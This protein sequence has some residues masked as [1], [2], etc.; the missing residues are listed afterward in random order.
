MWRAAITVPDTSTINELDRRMVDMER[1]ALRN[2]SARALLFSS[3]IL[4]LLGI[5]V[6]SPAGRMLFLVIA[7]I[8][9]GI[10]AL[11]GRGRARVFGVVVIVATLFLVA[12]SYPAYK[13]HMNQYLERAKEQ[14]T[15]IPDPSST[16]P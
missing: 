9:A 15:T 8:C 5:V 7:A 3:G 14:S 13:K 12:A 1:Q 4:V 11:L 2:Q 6:I 16:D 10:S